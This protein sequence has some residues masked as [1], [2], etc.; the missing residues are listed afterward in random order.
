MDNIDSTRQV[1]VRVDLII[2]LIT[3]PIF[4]TDRYTCCIVKDIM[5][6][7]SF[8]LYDHLSKGVKLHKHLGQAEDIICTYYNKH[9]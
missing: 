7:F 1:D 2:V 8:L 9:K 4:I 5:I 6:M 3:D